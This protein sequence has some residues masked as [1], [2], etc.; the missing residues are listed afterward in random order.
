M[1]ENEF[2]KLS[3][4]GE[5]QA[6]SMLISVAL[7]IAAKEGEE[8]LAL[9][10]SILLQM[11]SDWTTSLPE[12]YPDLPKEFLEVIAEAFSTQIDSVLS[13]TEVAAKAMDEAHDPSLH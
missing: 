12:L 2:F 1:N 13:T 8:K 10:R 11:K 5:R 4:R 6:N 7:A 9:L 3:L